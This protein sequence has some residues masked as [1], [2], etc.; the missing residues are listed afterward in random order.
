[1][2]MIRKLLTRSS[3]DMKSL[4]AFRKFREAMCKLQGGNSDN[5]RK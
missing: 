1:M 3:K 5:T 4:I 2:A